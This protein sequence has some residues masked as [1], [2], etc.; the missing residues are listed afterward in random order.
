MSRSQIQAWLAKV[1]RTVLIITL[2]LVVIRLILPIV[3]KETI[4]WY[5]GKKMTAYVGHIE[6]FDL[7]LWRGA[8]HLQGLEIKKRNSDL[9][10]LL[11]VQ[12]ADVS[13]AWRALFK[14]RLL[15][16]LEVNH[17]YLHFFDSVDFNKKQSGIED[18]ASWKETFQ[19]LVPL[20]VESLKVHNSAIFFSNHDLAKPVEVEL[21]DIELVARNI[22][23]SERNNEPV[24]SHLD[25]KARF[26]KSA[27][28]LVEGKFDLLAKELEFDLNMQMKNF[29][30]TSINPLI[31]AYGPL[32]F[33]TGQLSLYSELAAKRG[34]VA[35]YMNVFLGEIDIVAP[36]ESFIG[37]KHVF[38]ELAAAIGNLIFRNSKTKQVAFQLPISGP[39]KASTFLQLR[40]FDV[41]LKNAFEKPAE[42][43][44]RDSVNLKSVDTLLKN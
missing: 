3:G 4:N 28:L 11:K 37:I 8:Y 35:G 36:R 16:D 13:L 38:I 9:P 5:L 12:D 15:A 34:H 27:D 31:L 14:G 20:D 18:K 44:L 33:T 21:A 41:T 42:E 24:Y 7:A 30:L 26:Q 32:S 22:N 23:N 6:D 19:T 2:I 10:P 17:A 1:P 29:D 43:G 39:L 25:L 40:D